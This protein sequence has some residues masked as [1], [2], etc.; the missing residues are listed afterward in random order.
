MNRNCTV[1]V[2]P[3]SAP[4][5]IE[6]LKKTGRDRKKTK[7]VK[8][9]GNLK[10][11]DILKIA[12]TM[13]EAKKSMSVNLDGTCKEILGTCISLGCTVD[14]KSPKE[15]TKAINDGEIKVWKNEFTKTHITFKLD[16]ILS[17]WLSCYVT[18]WVCLLTALSAE[19][20]LNNIINAITHL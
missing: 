18:E 1:R 6:A 7:A 5:I 2:I 8:Y 10:F 14:G 12:K 9:D 20:K 11:D 3:S 4:L 15:I 13:R 16:I 19:C 17:Y